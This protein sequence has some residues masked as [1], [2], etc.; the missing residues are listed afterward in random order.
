MRNGCNQG[1]LQRH[2]P[3]P[4]V[5]SPDRFPAA[6]GGVK[7]F[8]KPV[9]A[10][11]QRRSDPVKLF[12]LSFYAVKH[13]RNYFRQVLTPFRTVEI[14]SGH[15]LRR[16]DPAKLFRLPFYAVKPHR[17]YFHRLLTAFRPAEI[18]S[19]GF[20]RRKMPSEIF[21]AIFYAVKNRS[22]TSNHTRPS[23]TAP[24]EES[25]EIRMMGLPLPVTLTAKDF[26]LRVR[27]TVLGTRWRRWP[28]RTRQ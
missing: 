22:Q 7:N 12:R 15:L 25:P 24:V 16:S 26:F 5:Q 14:I 3:A 13:R 10:H 8:R 2:G 18:I 28:Q 21:S 23:Q 1:G 17:N 4:Y 19:G 27:Q 9:P 20:L 11:S 6:F